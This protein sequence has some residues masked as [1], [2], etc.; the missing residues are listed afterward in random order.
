MNTPSHLI[1]NAA[2]HK[3]AKAGGAQGIARGAFL[4][5]AVLPDL[6]L[7]LLWVGGY[8][9]YRYGLVNTAFTIVDPLLDELY[10]TNRFW[11][12]S[13]NMFHAPLVLLS[14]M[15]LL[16]R[17]RGQAGT[18]RNWIFW[19]AAGCLI[20]TALDIPTHV[21]DGPLLLFPFEWSLRFRSP[22]SYWDSA[23]F[24]REFTVFELLLNL[25]LLAYLFG[26][27]LWGR[28]RRAG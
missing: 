5:G 24:G 21:T 17:F 3:R 25:V 19:L 4:L 16:W 23:Y 27:G 15:A 20:H 26:P 8:L 28:L 22:L 6:P 13:H 10:F 12:A 9:Y 18:R 7:W 11:I 14:T 2:L 1:I